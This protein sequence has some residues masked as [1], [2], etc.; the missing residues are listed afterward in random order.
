MKPSRRTFLRQAAASASAVSL[1]PFAASSFGADDPS[2]PSALPQSETVVKTLYDSLTERQHEALV[3]PFDHDLRSAVDNNWH[4]TPR[5]KAIGRFLTGDQQAMV[6]EIFV[7]LHSE[8]YRDQVMHQVDH[9]NGGRGL[10]P[11]NIAI[12]GEPGTGQF[13]FVLT[14]RHVTRRCDGD[15]VKG[16]AFGGPLFYGHAAESFHEEAHH[17]GNVYWF[18]AKRANEL[19]QM[20]GADQ[21]E[22][23]LQDRPR[24]ES[25]TS[26]VRLKGENRDLEG[27]AA[28]D[29]SPDQRQHLRKVMDD[30]LL[31]FRKEDR[32]ESLKLIEK[33]GWD[34][35]HLTFYR[36]HDI[37]N[38]GV[39]DTWQLESPH[40]LWYFRGKP[41]VHTWVHIRDPE[42]A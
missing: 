23:A 14:S 16:K 19:F 41:H 33:A 6:E 27:L 2:E 24:R 20:L 25:G 18:Q 22:A 30:L 34:T 36:N 31:P 42:T 37:G 10:R 7:N 1:G 13:E 35:L 11:A 3:F 4:I 12:F 40:M 32:D 17:P 8:E 15:S 28:A 21:R 9:D 38:D 39:W 26:T 29:M 5:D